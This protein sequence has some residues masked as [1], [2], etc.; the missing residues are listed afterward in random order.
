MMCMYYVLAVVFGG[1]VVTFIYETYREHREK[2]IV[3]LLAPKIEAL[4]EMSSTKI[5]ERERKLARPLTD[6]EKDRIADE[7]YSKI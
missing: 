7:C 2:E 1:A 3:R 6:L 5:S 4:I